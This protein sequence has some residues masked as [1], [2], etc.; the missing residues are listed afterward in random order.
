MLERL[1]G[2]FFTPSETSKALALGV[3]ALCYVGIAWFVY[4]TGGVKFATLH[5]LYLPIIFAA[6]IF[7]AGGGIVA[8]AVGGLLLGPDVPLDTGTG[9]TQQLGNWL[10]R[11]AFFCAVG[12]IVGAGAGT[13]RKQVKILDWLNEHDARTVLL[14]RT[15]LLNTLRQMIERDGQQTRPLLIIVQINNLLAVQN[16]LGTAFGEKLLKQ[17]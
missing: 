8:G 13:L 17:I 7:G 11:A 1:R 2:T 3:L 9:E 16:T 5:I 10:L 6:L 12:G 14:D 4:F 15:G